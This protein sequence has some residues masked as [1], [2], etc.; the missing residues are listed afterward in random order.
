MKKAKLKQ[1]AT[2]KGFDV[3]MDNLPY[4]PPHPLQ[5]PPGQHLNWY[6][7]ALLQLVK[8]Y[9]FLITGLSSDHLSARQIY[10]PA[11]KGPSFI[12]VH[13]AA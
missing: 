12:S 9:L 6:E 10:F 13:A 11:Q 8:I 4:P 5:W 2:L 7:S 1:W 3:F